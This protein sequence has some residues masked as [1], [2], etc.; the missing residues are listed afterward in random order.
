MRLAREG[1]RL[2]KTSGM[3]FQV[4]EEVLR[5]TDETRKN[6][7]NGDRVYFE[8]EEMRFP[9]LADTLEAIGEGGAELLYEGELGRRS[10]EYVLKMGGIITE[11]DLAEYRAILREPLSVAYEQGEIYTNGPPS[12]GGPDARPDAKDSVRLRSGIP[13]RGRIRQGHGGCYEARLARPRGRLR[14][15]GGER[16]RSPEASRAR[17]T[18]GSSAGASSARRRPRTSPASTPTGSPSPSPPRWATGPGSS[19]PAPASR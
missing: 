11:R 3:W 15:W 9:E 2:C 8:G 10:S 18:P 6:F 1:F 4:A 12:A 13:P 16:D 5:L 7:Y 17:S 19:C 14:G